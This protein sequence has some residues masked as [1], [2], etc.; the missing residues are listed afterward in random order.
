MCLSFFLPVHLSS[1]LWVHP[2]IYLS[3]SHTCTHASTHARARARARAHTHTFPLTHSLS[4]PHPLSLP[5]FFLFLVKKQTK[6][7]QTNAQGLDHCMTRPVVLRERPTLEADAYP[8][9][10][11]HTLAIKDPEPCVTSQSYCLRS[12]DC[13]RWNQVQDFRGS[14]EQIFLDHN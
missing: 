3:Y 13:L 6:N 12:L 14:K 9:D 8:A 5:T 4:L 2:S 7:K 10:L 11:L 1:G